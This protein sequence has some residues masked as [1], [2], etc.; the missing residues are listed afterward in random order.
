MGTAAAKD[1]ITAVITESFFTALAFEFWSHCGV[2]RERRALRLRVPISDAVREQ[3]E[4]SPPRSPVSMTQTQSIVS[5]QMRNGAF[6]LDGPHSPMSSS[7]AGK[8]AFVLN[9][10]IAP[11][12]KLLCS[13]VGHKRLSDYQ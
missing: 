11:H 10:I 6:L 1:G 3:D 7:Y 9:L 12:L 2:A 8:R 13:C 4:T 5:F